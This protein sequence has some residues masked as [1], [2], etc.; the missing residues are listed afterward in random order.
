MT[1]RLVGLVREVLAADD[2]TAAAVDFHDSLVYAI[3]RSK[4][5]RWHI[6]GEPSVD[7]RQHGG[8]VLGSN[9]G[10][11]AAMTR[12]ALIRSHWHRHHATKLTTVSTRVGT[13]GCPPGPR[14]HPRPAPTKGPRARI[15]TRRS[16]RPSCGA[17]RA[18]A[19]SS[20]CSSRP[21]YGE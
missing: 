21:E 11:R 8:N 3:A 10:G 19:A 4:G 15:R 16:S 14:A 2:G 9:S 1:Q 5:W 13:A 6:D 12:L 7:Y 18:T 20:A 17:A